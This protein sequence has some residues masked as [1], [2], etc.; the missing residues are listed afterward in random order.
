MVGNPGQ[1]AL[2]IVSVS[3]NQRDQK[4]LE[5]QLRW[6]RPSQRAGTM[7]SAIVAVFVGGITLCGLTLSGV[8][9]ARES[10]PIINAASDLIISN[11]FSEE[12]PPRTFQ[13]LLSE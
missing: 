12:A 8:L 9:F 1:S 2:F 5:K 13:T 7:A 10:D 6:L 4:L 11:A 3:M